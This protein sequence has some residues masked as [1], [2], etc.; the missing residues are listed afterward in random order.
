MPLMS[1]VSPPRLPAHLS[2]KAQD[3][4]TIVDTNTDDSMKSGMYASLRQAASLSTK[5]ITS[6]RPESPPIKKKLAPLRHRH[7]NANGMARTRQQANQ[8]I[9]GLSGLSRADGCRSEE[10]HKPQVHQQ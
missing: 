9:L 5:I 6:R 1:M 2:L 7:F 4:F 10:A 3:A 8:E